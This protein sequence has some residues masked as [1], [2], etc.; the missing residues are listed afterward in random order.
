MKKLK[1]IFYEYPN[2][3]ASIKLIF[4]LYL[5]FLSLQL[6][7][8][9]MKL[10]GKEFAN[11]LIQTTSNPLVGL[12]IGILATSIVQSSSS[13]TSIVVGMVA[14]GALNIHNAIPIIM[15]ANIGTSIT[16]TI[17]SLPQINRSNEFRRAF[18]AATVHD[19]FNFLAVIV[20]FPLQ[21]ATNFLGVASEAFAN[22]FQNVG[23]LTFL[24]P[25]KEITKPVSYYFIAQLKSGV[26]DGFLYKWI[27]LFVALLFLF[28]ALKYM[29]DSLKIL[30][31]SK[32]RAWFDQFLFKTAPRAMVVGLL[33]TILVQS[34]SIT[35]SLVVPMAG[36]GLLTLI[37]IFPYT[38]GAN[39]GTTVTAILAALITGNIAAVTVAFAHLL[40]N[41]AGIVIWMPLK[42]VPITMAERFAEYSIKN[43][44]IPVAY[45]V[46]LFF[47]V[48]I[49]VIYIMN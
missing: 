21:V 40:F 44:L 13:T 22:M 23:G 27:A 47:I 34:S 30:I 2:L 42:I 3:I 48:P 19:F 36:A 18:A 49:L 25:V 24:S 6:M 12:F 11:T 38:L 31:M 43:K 45:V 39:V 5:F 7:G 10:F 9:S 1:I 14:G 33:L 29:T 35:T 46:I 4:F 16:N 15:G 26:S 32:A 17:A 37:Q 20:L 28:V 8:D 41:I